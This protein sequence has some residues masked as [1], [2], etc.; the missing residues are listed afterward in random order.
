MRSRARGH[1]IELAVLD[2]RGG[3]KRRYLGAREPAV[4]A[5]RTFRPDV[6]YAHFLVPPG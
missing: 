5:A 6:V 3:G 4:R 1:E 2:R